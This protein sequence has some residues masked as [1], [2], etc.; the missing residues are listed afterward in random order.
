MTRGNKVSSS[1]HRTGDIARLSFP[2]VFQAC[3]TLERVLRGPKVASP[4]VPQ[5]S[6]GQEDRVEARSLTD[7]DLRLA[8]PRQPPPTH[9]YRFG[10][11]NAPSTKLRRKTLLIPSLDFSY[12]P[13]GDSR[14]LIQA[15]WVDPSPPLSTG[16]TR[17]EG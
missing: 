8:F 16:Q 2:A 3:L 1:A 12:R 9:L 5:A 7:T 4:S 17:L 11:G 15:G 13:G 6:V 14:P 10:L